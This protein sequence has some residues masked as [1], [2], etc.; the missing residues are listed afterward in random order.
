LPDVSAACGEDHH[1]SIGATSNFV[2]FDS[3]W[4]S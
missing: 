3:P 1:I 2:P 4:M